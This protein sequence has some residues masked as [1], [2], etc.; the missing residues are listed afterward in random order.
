MRMF[1][2]HDTP[3]L[4][5]LANF[6]TILM[7]KNLPLPKI[8]ISTNEEMRVLVNALQLKFQDMKIKKRAKH[9]QQYAINYSIV[10]VFLKINWR[11][12][13]N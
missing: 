7:Q 3:N 13:K 1:R 6:L 5:Y 10:I 12:L 4:I 2:L 11:N 8:Y 9:S